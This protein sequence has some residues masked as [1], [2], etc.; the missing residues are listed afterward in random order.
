MVLSKLF[1][2]VVLILTPTGVNRYRQTT[3]ARMVNTVLMRRDDGMVIVCNGGGKG[4]RVVH[5]M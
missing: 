5:A 1:Q 2:T 4:E 3:M